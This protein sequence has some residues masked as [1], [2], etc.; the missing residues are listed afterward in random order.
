[1][2]GVSKTLKYG[3]RLQQLFYLVGVIKKGLYQCCYGH[4]YYKRDAELGEEAEFDP[5]VDDTSVD[6]DF[7]SPQKRGTLYG[8]C[9]Y[10][11]YYG[12]DKP[13]SNYYGY[14]PFKKGPAG[15][16]GKKGE[17]GEPG[18]PGAPGEPGDDGEDGKPGAPGEKGQKGEP[19]KPGPYGSP[20]YH[21]CPTQGAKGPHGA[22]GEK[23][24]EGPQG[25]PGLPGPKG[26]PCKDYYGHDG[27]DGEDGYPGIDGMKG[28]PG[29]PGEP[30][31]K[32]EPSDGDISPEEFEKFK[33]LL[34]KFDAVRANGKCC[35]KPH[36]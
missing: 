6:I 5:E 25:P 23:G 28:E 9:R 14:C 4:Y 32:G 1:M 3:K 27:A 17:D 10:T 21:Y 7:S 8:R 15:Y 33:L 26:E 31:P 24:E 19:G 35:Y 11:V 29:D 13:C 2:Q 22:K 16:R 20:Y 30:G 36:Y 12:D 18:E 34:K